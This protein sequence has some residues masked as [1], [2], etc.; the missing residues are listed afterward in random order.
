MK[1]KLSPEGPTDLKLLGRLAR[2]C[3]ILLRL[4]DRKVRRVARCVGEDILTLEMN[5]RAIDAHFQRKPGPCHS[6]LL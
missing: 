6:P 3:A 4:N 5:A 2:A 1:P